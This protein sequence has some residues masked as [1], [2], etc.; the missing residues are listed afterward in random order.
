MCVHPNMRT[1]FERKS[2]SEPCRRKDGKRIRMKRYIKKRNLAKKHSS[3]STNNAF[4]SVHEYR[5]SFYATLWMLQLHLSKCCDEL[6]KFKCPNHS[7]LLLH[8]YIGHYFKVDDFAKNKQF[9][10]ESRHTRSRGR[11][12]H[13]KQLRMARRKQKVENA[14]ETRCYYYASLWLLQAYI[15]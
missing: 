12:L 4:D 13:R 5:S 10:N 1:L 8:M 6:V 7:S 14:I 11:Y 15:V 9:E 2:G 3:C